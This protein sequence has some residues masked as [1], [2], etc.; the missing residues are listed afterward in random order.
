MINHSERTMVVREADLSDFASIFVGKMCV[1]GASTK[2]ATS[3]QKTTS[4]KMG[5]WFSS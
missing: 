5:G 3:F 1:F 4:P 2:N